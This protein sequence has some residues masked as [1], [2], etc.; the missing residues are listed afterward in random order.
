M[1]LLIV[2]A[3]SSRSKHKTFAFNLLSAHT[4]M[5]Q[6]CLISVSSCT[7]PKEP[8]AVCSG[9]LM[10]SFFLWY[11]FLMQGFC[12]WSLQD[13][14]VH[15]AP[16]SLRLP[17]SF[18]GAQCFPY[19]ESSTTK[20]AIYLVQ[21]CLDISIMSVGSCCPNNLDGPS[22]LKKI[23]RTGRVLCPFRKK[24]LEPLTTHSWI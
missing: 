19:C 20:G 18:W 5:L 17:I 3:S 24:T 7:G 1:S 11:A 16:L 6:L 10:Q 13:R 15:F 4:S 9:S 8:S 23:I 21:W 2:R 14:G 22:T 12:S